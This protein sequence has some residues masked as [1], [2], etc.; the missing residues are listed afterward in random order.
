LSTIRKISDSTEAELIGFV[1]NFWSTHKKAPSIDILKESIERKSSSPLLSE[2]ITEYEELYEELNLHSVLDLDQILADRVEEYETQRLSDVLKVVRQINSGSVEEPKT[3]KKLSGPKDAMRYLFQQVERGT[4]A[5]GSKNS[6]GSLNENGSY[7]R[8]LYEK[9]KSER[10]AGRLRIYTHINGIDDHL[11]V[12]RGDFVG[13]LG[14]AGQRK[15]ALCRSIA[16]Y[17]ALDGFNVLHITLEQ[18]YEEELIIYGIMHSYHPKWGSRF[19]LDKKAFDDGNFTDEEEAFL[20]NEV[21]PDLPNL[22]GKLLI[23]QPIESTTW[24]AVKTTAEIANQTDQLD[25]LLVDYLTLCETRTGKKEEMEVVIKD[26]KQFALHFDN[27]RGVVFMTP[28]QGNRAGWEKAGES[29]GRWEINGVN[30]YS[31]FDKSV[32]TMLTVFLN[33]DLKAEKALV[34]SSAK[35][36]RSEGVPVFKAAMQNNC[37]LV[38]NMNSVCLVEDKRMDDIIETFF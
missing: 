14:Y 25:I 21:I 12:K 15:S 37:G 6:H 29:E 18:T 5:T 35:T 28:V 24:D 34:V 27:G 36:R 11:A 22:P 20:F 8:E 3:K 16:Y 32:D 4:L 38:S 10:L 31:E 9:F 13:V 30:M 2:R 17:A 1:Y 33:D 26:A 7:I 19:K 23:R